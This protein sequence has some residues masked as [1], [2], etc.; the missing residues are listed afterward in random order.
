IHE[1]QDSL[2]CVKQW[3]VIGAQWPVVSGSAPQLMWGQPPSAVRAARCIGPPAWIRCRTHYPFPALAAR[4]FFLAAAAEVVVSI[5][6]AG[7]VSISSAG[8]GAS[9]SVRRTSGAGAG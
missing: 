8:A 6:D 4:T 7:D 5:S 3:P 9:T 2:D 1:R